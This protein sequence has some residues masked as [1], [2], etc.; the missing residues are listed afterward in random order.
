ILG[1][2]IWQR[3]FGGDP[4]V[5]GRVMQ[6]NA[7][8]QTIVGVMPRGFRL[9]IKDG[10]LAGKPSDMWAPYV[11]AANARDFGGRYMEAIGHLRSRAGPR[12]SAKSRFAPRS[13]RRASASSGNCSPTAS[14]SRSSAAW[15]VW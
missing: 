5:V 11:L 14:C 8:P 1:Y 15:S 7:R 4:G 9:F 10:S 3:R 2:D 12:G 6:L 13:E